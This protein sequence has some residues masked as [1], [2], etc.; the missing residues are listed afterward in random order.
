MAGTAYSYGYGGSSP[1]SAY[2][3]KQRLSILEPIVK[4][5]MQE[6]GAAQDSQP[7]YGSSISEDRRRRNQTSV[8]QNMLMA[9]LG[10]DQSAWNSNRDA[11]DRYQ[12]AMLQYKMQMQQLAAQQKQW[13]DQMNRMAQMRN[14]QWK[15][16]GGG[17]QF[18]YMPSP[19]SGPGGS[20]LGMMPG[21]GITGI[22]G[23]IPGSGP[24]NNSI[25]DQFNSAISGAPSFGS[26]AGNIGYNA[27]AAMPF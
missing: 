26:T 19:M 20:G 25:M 4:Q 15:Q 14:D 5:K 6:W 18:G 9:M 27:M 17:T 7:G 3:I 1:Q 10:L 21:G 24:G 2:D 16:H 23:A 22:G 11:W 13:Q 8:G 12:T